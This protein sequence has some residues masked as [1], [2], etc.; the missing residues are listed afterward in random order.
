MVKITVITVV[1]NDERNIQSTIE[2]VLSQTYPHIEYIVIDGG[3]GDGTK[4]ILDNYR[5]HIDVLINEP[6]NGIYDAMNKGIANASGNWIHFLNS[7]D[8]YVDERAVERM[9][10]YTISNPDVN[11]VYTSGV[12]NLDIEPQQLSYKYLARRAM[13]HQSIIFS[14]SLF[15]KKQYDTRY[16]YFADYEHILSS[17]PLANALCV[18]MDFVKY[19]IDGVSS[20]TKNLSK[21]WK[22]RAAIIRESNMPAHLRLPAVTYAYMAYLY[23]TMHKL[24]LKF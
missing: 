1:Y 13:N 9:M 7:A 11:F 14:K 4:Q 8:L 6:D 2:S 12:F 10:S 24:L 5:K 18:N 3:S 16:K 21:L 20:D 22:E 15:L 17:V 23:R 19:N